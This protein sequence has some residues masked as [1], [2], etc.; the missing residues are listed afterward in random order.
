VR[1]TQ[2]SDAMTSRLPRYEAKYVCNESASNAGRSLCV[3]I[4]RE[5]SYPVPIYWYHSKGAIHWATTLSLTVY[6]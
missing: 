6:I 3:Q 2:A 4:S 1:R 5:L